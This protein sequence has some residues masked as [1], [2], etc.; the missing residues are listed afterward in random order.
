MFFAD[1]ETLVRREILLLNPSFNHIL[2]MLAE[3]LGEKNQ[4]SLV[5]LSGCFLSD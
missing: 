4:I 2:S 3:K 5:L 1:G